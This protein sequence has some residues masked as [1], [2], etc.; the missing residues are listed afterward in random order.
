MVR[1]N[2]TIIICIHTPPSIY[3][4]VCL[5]VCLS[6]YLSIYLSIC[7]SI[8]LSITQVASWFLL[9]LG[10]HEVSHAREIHLGFLTQASVNG[11]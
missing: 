5:S 4:S 9:Q 1:S 3:L 8:S 10:H 7:L 6:I 11:L 2:W